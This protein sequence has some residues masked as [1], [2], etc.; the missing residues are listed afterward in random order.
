[1]RKFKKTL[2]GDICSLRLYAQ[3]NCCANSSFCYKP[4][5]FRQKN[6]YKIHVH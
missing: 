4:D 2:R 5:V 6:M 1:M 3:K